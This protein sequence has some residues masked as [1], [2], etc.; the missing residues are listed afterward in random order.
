MIYA[1]SGQ[2]NAVVPRSVT[3]PAHVQVVTPAGAT[4][5]GPTVALNA[6]PLPG[7]FQDSHTG[8]AAALNQDGGGA[9]VPT[10]T[11]ITGADPSG[12]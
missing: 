2:I 9:V 3:D 8:L 4:V 10:E 12:R 7:I 11:Y 6:Q 5:D 1:D